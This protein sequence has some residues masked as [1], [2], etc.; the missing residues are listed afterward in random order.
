V[1]AHA[2][3]F[4]KKDEVRLKSFF[5]VAGMDEC[6]YSDVGN[7]DPLGPWTTVSIPSYQVI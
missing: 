5:T 1:P 4:V 3:L 2:S 6:S 7:G